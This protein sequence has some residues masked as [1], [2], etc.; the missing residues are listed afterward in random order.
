M[1]A[2]KHRPLPELLRQR[3]PVSK[4]KQRIR[5]SILG[6]KNKKI[7]LLKNIIDGRE[8]WFLPGGSV[9]WGETLAEAAIREA[10][11]ELQI[12]I[13][14]KEMI[15]IL[16]SISP[17]KD[18][19]SIDVIFRSDFLGQPEA[20]GE[21]SNVKETTL[22][23]YA[24]QGKWVDLNELRTLEV[25]PKKFLKVFLPKYL[26]GNNLVKPFVGLDWD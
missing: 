12:H 23:T 4:R 19:H 16:D 11:E 6:V 26:V 3:G 18:F 20:S 25:Y 9:E 1:R 7:Y 17:A 24:I 14:I 10:M 13:K 15:A 22:N 2:T 21:R 8:I 5:A